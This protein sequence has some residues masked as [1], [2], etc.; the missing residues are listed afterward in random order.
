LPVCHAVT[1]IDDTQLLILQ[2]Q[3]AKM[4]AQVDVLQKEKVAWQEDKVEMQTRTEHL[5]AALKLGKS[6]GYIKNKKDIARY[7]QRSREGKT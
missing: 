6:K 1:M 3:L 4:Q 7:I 5:V 2:E